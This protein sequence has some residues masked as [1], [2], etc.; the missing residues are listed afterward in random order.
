MMSNR[1]QHIITIFIFI[2]SVSCVEGKTSEFS[3]EKI[4]AK[5]L[6][7]PKPTI[8]PDKIKKLFGSGIEKTQSVDFNG[9]N[10]EDYLVTIKND[11]YDERNNDIVSWQVWVTSDYRILK[12][13]P[14]YPADYDYIWFVNLDEDPEPEFITGWGFSDGM[15]YSIYDQDITHNTDKLLFIFTPVVISQEKNKEDFSL[16]FAGDI[17]EIC[18]NTEGKL[19]CALKHNYTSEDESDISENQNIVPLLFFFGK[20]SD[21][22]LE[23][24]IVRSREWLTIRQIIEATMKRERKVR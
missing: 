7:A 11:M 1:L 12:K 18:V 16:A 9:D 20:S 8:T 15:N 19:F 17:A 3:E 2:F 21:A 13:K 22:N 5:T 23:K 6:I 10:V 24:N 4:P 14:K